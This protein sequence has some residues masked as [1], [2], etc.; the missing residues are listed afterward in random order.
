M[1][2][3][4]VVAALRRWWYVTTMIVLLIGGAATA[5]S[6]LR[7]PEYKATA[8]VF[9]SLNRSPAVSELAQGSTYTQDVVKSYS[10]VVTLPVVLSPVISELGLDETP[11]ELARRVSIQTQPDTVIADITVTDSS[12]GGAAELANAIATELGK[13][14]QTLSPGGPSSPAA[15]RVTRISAAEIPQSRSSPNIP[16]LIGIGVFGGLLLGG[17]AAIV[18]ELVKS[19]LITEEVARKAAPVVGKIARD[20]RARS[21]PLPL[22]TH[23]QLPIAESF[24]ALRTNLRRLES[25][26]QSLCLVVASALPKEGRTTVASNLAIA[27]SHSFHSVLLVDADLRRPALAR[28]FGLPQEPGLSDLLQGETSLYDITQTWKLET[29]RES[30]VHVVPAGSRSTDPSE[31]LARP[32]MSK[33]LESAKFGYQFVLMDTAPLLPVTDGALL[34]AQVDGAL[35][36]VHSRRTTERDFAEAVTAL[37][38]AGAQI[39]GIIINSVRIPRWF[40]GRRKLAEVPA[41]SVAPT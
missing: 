34:A 26:Q 3:R 30:T 31:L 18:L 2:L 15:V 23:P 39:S 32:A 16:L 17:A 22:T 4:H 6:F 25:S 1:D 12:A 33:M 37:Q 20:A 36:V 7:T 29:W 27:M 8:T 9:F 19:P 14:A 13:A 10:Q 24:H 41:R 5:Y 38:L 21:R 40:R 35:L 28:T 11:T